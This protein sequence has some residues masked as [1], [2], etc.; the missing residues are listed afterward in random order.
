MILC[1]DLSGTGGIGYVSNST[2][3]NLSASTS[4]ST[5]VLV[6]ALGEQWSHGITNRI[7]LH[8]PY[9]QSNG[10]VSNQTSAISYQSPSML[11]RMATLMKSP[12]M[13]NKSIPFAVTAK[14]IRDMSTV[15]PSTA[16]SQLSSTTITV[17]KSLL[18]FSTTSFDY[19]NFYSNQPVNKLHQ[20]E[21]CLGM[22]VINDREISKRVSV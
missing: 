4:I 21:E 7:L 3:R 10:I 11:V 16:P 5:T 1:I 14:G 22:W 8:Y 18:F 9:Q 20:D 15:I 12:S 13:A 6:P 19:C 2:R 17:R